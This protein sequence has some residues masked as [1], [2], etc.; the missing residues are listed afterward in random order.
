METKHVVAALIR[1]GE[2][3]FATRRGYGEMKGGWE[4]PGGKVAPG[5]SPGEALVREI[6]EELDT[7]ISV[8]RLF[9]VVEYD[10]PEFHL[11][12]ECYFCTVIRGDLILKEHMDARWFTA[13]DL[14]SVDWLSADLNLIPRLKEEGFALRNLVFDVGHV[15][16]QYRWKEMFMDFGLDEENSIRIGETMFS[17]PIWTDKFDRGIWGPDRMIQE[18][19]TFMP[20]EDL[21]YVRLFL[22]NAKDMRGE[23]RTE[24]WESIR[25]LREKGYRIYILS[26]YSEYLFS[27]HTEDAP[28]MDYM[29]GKVVSYEPKMIK[30]ERGIY[31]Y[32]M[33]KYNL[34]IQECLFFDDRL[35]NV[36]KGHELGMDG[37]LVTSRQMLGST[38]ESL[39]E[40]VFPSSGEEKPDT[41]EQ[42]NI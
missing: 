40:P 26:N 2:Y 35:E 15:L 42:N 29:D 19:G 3:L 12:M 21:A 20:P 22:K 41:K 28:F 38:L 1:K 5:E 27:L 8:G 36:E 6:R 14:D 37:V 13:D 32:L 9:D 30:P 23:D 33:N 18:Y 34:N 31:D 25:L 24:I 4:F 7:E 10:Y 16:L 17:A 11:S 39:L